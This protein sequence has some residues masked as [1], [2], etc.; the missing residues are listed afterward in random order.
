MRQ[1]F[2]KINGIHYCSRSFGRL[3]SSLDEV[4]DSCLKFVATLYEKAKRH[5]QTICVPPFSKRKLL[6]DIIY[7]PNRAVCHMLWLH[8]QCAHFQTAF[9]QAYLDPHGPKCRWLGDQWVRAS[10][11]SQST[12]ADSYIQDNVLNLFSCGCKTVRKNCTLLS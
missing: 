1:L 4:T 3:S 2:L 11:S 10:T 7:H 6:A 5:G 9:C 12:R 8:C